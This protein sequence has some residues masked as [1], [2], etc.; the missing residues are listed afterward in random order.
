MCIRD[1][2][3]TEALADRKKMEYWMPVDWYNGGMEHVTRHI[4]YSRFWHHFL[5][6]MGIEMCIRD[7]ID[8]DVRRVVMILELEQEREHSSMAVSYTHLDVY[9]R[10]ENGCPV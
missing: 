10:Q 6:D 7:S 9:K 3:N 2:H 5:Y 4:I 1:R 8:A